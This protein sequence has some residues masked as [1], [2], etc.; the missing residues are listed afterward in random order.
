MVKRQE[1]DGVLRSNVS[2]LDRVNH[3]IVTGVTGCVRVVR[4][5]WHR[6]GI[7]VGTIGSGHFDDYLAHAHDPYPVTSY[8]ERNRHDRLPAA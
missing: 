6:E 2:R 7:A 8:S 5:A 3:V 1:A 4:H